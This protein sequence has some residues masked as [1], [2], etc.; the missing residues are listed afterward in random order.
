M[1]W[2]RG[3]I[4]LW[5]L[6]AVL[7]SIGAGIYIYDDSTLRPVKVQIDGYGVV[8]FPPSFLLL[9]NAAQN[10]AVEDATEQ[11]KAGQRE[12]LEAVAWAGA[13]RKAVRFASIIVAPPICLL[14]LGLAVAWV[15]NGFRR[16]T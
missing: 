11:I 16:T 1:N 2:A 3:L 5:A 12:A 4:R 14:T 13:Y 9:G 10:N 8:H 7:W 15:L 6:I